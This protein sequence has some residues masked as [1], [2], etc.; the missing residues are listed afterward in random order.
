MKVF[1][2]TAKVAEIVARGSGQCAADVDREW[3]L[4]ARSAFDPGADPSDQAEAALSVAADILS[5]AG[6]LDTLD[7]ETELAERL[8]LAGAAARC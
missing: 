7:P 1:Q 3:K 6:Y 5:E 4:A 8:I 2:F